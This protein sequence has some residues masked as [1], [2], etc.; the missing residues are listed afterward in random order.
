VA[1]SFK[2][3][4]QAEVNVGFRLTNLDSEMFQH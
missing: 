4:K 2:K 3:N 1:F